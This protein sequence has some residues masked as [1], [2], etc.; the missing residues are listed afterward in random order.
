MISAEASNINFLF[1][2]FLKQWVVL[3]LRL[4]AVASI[5][6]LSVFF[7]H[8]LEFLLTFSFDMITLFF[9]LSPLIL[10]KQL[11][12]LLDDFVILYASR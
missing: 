12:F 8:L 6:V 5:S 2:L 10:Y 1:R 4:L 7:H 3:L 9:N 11:E